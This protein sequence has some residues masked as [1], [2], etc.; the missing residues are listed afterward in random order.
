MRSTIL[1]ALAALGM[2]AA[3][4]GCVIEPLGYHGG[5]HHHYRY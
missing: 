2:L 5:Y 3:L 1:A 4:T